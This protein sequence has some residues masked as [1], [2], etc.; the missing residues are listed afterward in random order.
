MAVLPRQIEMHRCLIGN[1]LKGCLAVIAAV[2]MADVFA[3]AFPAYAVMGS[4]LI[5]SAGLAAGYFLCVKLAYFK[6][7]R[8]S[9]GEEG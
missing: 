6:S 8:I 1:T 3:Q 7:V 2:F 4:S 9:R 5:L